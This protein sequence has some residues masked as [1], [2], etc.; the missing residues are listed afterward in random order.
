[1]RFWGRLL[2]GLGVGDG[3]RCGCDGVVGWVGLGEDGDDYV[4]VVIVVGGGGC[5]GGL[6]GGLLEEACGRCS[7]WVV[8]DGFG[9][10]RLDSLG[11]RNRLCCRRSE[12]PWLP[13]R[14]RIDKF[15]I[16][17][18]EGVALGNG[19]FWGRGDGCPRPIVAE[20]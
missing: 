11:L 8:V 20:T 10:A 6:V 16:A 4:V 9:V 13:C 2:L 18:L 5:C 1:M 14:I 12:G 19:Q 17:R 3:G 7:C 15:R